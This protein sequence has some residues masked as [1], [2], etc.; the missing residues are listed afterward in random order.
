MA[1][2]GIGEAGKSWGGRG[3]ARRKDKSEQSEPMGEKLE[4]ED[5]FVGGKIWASI[6][7]L[8]WCL[9][10]VYYKVGP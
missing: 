7:A 5:L 10:I 9:C 4:N 1:W 8:G 2:R 3:K 6:R